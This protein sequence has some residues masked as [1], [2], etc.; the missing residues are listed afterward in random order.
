MLSRKQAITFR[1]ANPPSLL[2]SWQCPFEQ[3]PVFYTVLI[4]GFLFSTLLACN[5]PSYSILSKI[6]LQTQVQ[7]Q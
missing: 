1:L 7:S 3:K 4:F 2:S 5:Y 6:V